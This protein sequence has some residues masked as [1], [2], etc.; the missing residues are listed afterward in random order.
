MQKLSDEDIERIAQRVAELIPRQT[1]VNVP[2]NPVYP[3]QNPWSFPMVWNGTHST[4]V[5][6]RNV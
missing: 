4:D 6:Y 3:Y 2:V 1:I 5:L